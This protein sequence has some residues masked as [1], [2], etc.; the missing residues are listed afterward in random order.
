[1]YTFGLR[2]NECHLE[3]NFLRICF[4]QHLEG[5]QVCFQ[6]FADLPQSRTVRCPGN[7][8]AAATKSTTLELQ[9][10]ARLNSVPK[11]S[12]TFLSA[13]ANCASTEHNTALGTCI[14]HRRISWKFAEE[15]H[16]VDTCMKSTS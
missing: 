12:K 14:A 15:I 2:T 6:T 5:V 8:M 16:P 1:M 7:D 4:S 11:I 9:K 10:I 3:H 13:Q